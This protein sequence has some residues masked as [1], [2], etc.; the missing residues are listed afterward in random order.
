[1]SDARD[2]DALAAAAEAGPGDDATLAALADA[3]G[4]AA[5]PARLALLKKW[6]AGFARVGPLREELKALRRTPAPSPQESYVLHA[7]PPIHHVNLDGGP[8]LACELTLDGREPAGYAEDFI[9]RRRDALFAALSR[10]VAPGHRY[11]LR[12]TRHETPA[13]PSAP[14]WMRHRRVLLRLRITPLD[15]GPV[16]LPDGPA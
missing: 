15:G 4:E 13:D 5:G 3:L 9:G 14:P 12:L 6:V 2:L 8:E 16:N 7:H 11:A 1:V 10:A